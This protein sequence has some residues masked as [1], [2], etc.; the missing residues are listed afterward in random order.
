MHTTQLLLSWVSSSLSRLYIRNGVWTIES[1]GHCVV[2]SSV[3]G[4][5]APRRILLHLFSVQRV[6]L[7]LVDGRILSYVTTN[8]ITIGHSRFIGPRFSHEKYPSES[9]CLHRNQMDVLT[10]ILSLLSSGT[11]SRDPAYVCLQQPR[12][13]C[14][15][16]RPYI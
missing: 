16:S 2:C 7:C 12:T 14:D 4:A 1:V 3:N 5:L 9:S 6:A 13:P 15:L 8:P 10:P 11:P